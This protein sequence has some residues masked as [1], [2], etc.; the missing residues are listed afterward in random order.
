MDDY[1]DEGT[2]ALN[3]ILAACKTVEWQLKGHKVFCCPRCLAV[4]HN[5]NDVEQRY[6]SRCKW[7]IRDPGPVSQSTMHLGPPEEPKPK[8]VAEADWN[9]LHHHTGGH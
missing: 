4:S 8:R 7:F 2:L 5:L 3:K 6:C 1:I 9:E